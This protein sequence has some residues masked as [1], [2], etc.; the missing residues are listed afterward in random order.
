M[1]LVQIGE[2][3]PDHLL[4]VVIKPDGKSA[5]KRIDQSQNQENTADFF[6][7]KTYNNNLLTSR[8]SY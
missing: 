5:L 8:P 1:I 6:Q 3:I 7:S 4:L 2:I